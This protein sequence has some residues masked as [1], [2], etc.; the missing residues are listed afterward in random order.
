M[1][2]VEWLGECELTS[3]QLL[4]PR[5]GYLGSKRK[6]DEPTVDLKAAILDV[7]TTAEVISQRELLNRLRSKGIKVR[8]EVFRRTIHG[9]RDH[10]ITYDGKGYR[11]YK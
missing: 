2:W 8:D 6:A 4:A 9:M 1:P 11:I 10:E 3:E 7:V 5:P